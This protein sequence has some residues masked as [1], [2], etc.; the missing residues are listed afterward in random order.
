MKKSNLLPIAAVLAMAACQ[1]KVDRFAVS[2]A[3]MD[4]QDHTLYL[5]RMDIDR[6]VTVDS[7]K[8]GQDGN[9][10]FRQPAPQDCFELYRLRLGSGTVNFAVDS[11]QEIS[12]T[13]RMSDMQTAYVIEGSASSLAMKSVAERQ[14]RFIT[15]LK[16][17]RQR[18]AGPQVGVLDAHIGELLE[19]FKSDLC[20]E[21]IFPNPGSPAA[22]YCLF[23]SVNGHRIFNPY[24]GRQDAKTFA[25]V[26]SSMD[27]LYP[28]SERTLHLH[29]L[30]LKA[31][32]RT[33]AT[34]TVTQQ[35]AEWLGSV[36]SES[37][38]IDMELP[39]LNGMAHKL[40]DLKGKVV[41]LDLTAYKTDFSANYN[42]VLRKLYDKYSGQGLEIYQVSFDN[43]ES[44]WMNAAVSVPWICVRDENSLDSDILKLYN[45]EQLPAAFII[46]RNGD[47]V[48]R[49]DDS[50]QLDAAIGKLL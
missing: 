9:F 20:N 45:V 50:S 48:E 6:I 7:V 30:A 35:Q 15:D 41:L 1:P 23:I 13:A 22:Y 44:F 43:D 34:N 11:V 37:G 25:S 27:M 8:L 47:I 19:V 2:G 28:E 5:E 18:F 3:I 14:Y 36:V 33:S 49:P 26:A 10:C 4:A 39:D 24:A 38:L 16:E 29:N 17:L 12:I 21:F 46:D 31:M 32:S 42:M 40:S